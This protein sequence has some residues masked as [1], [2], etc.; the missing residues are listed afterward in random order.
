VK[1]A[2]ILDSGPLGVLCNP[3]NFAQ[4]LAIRAWISALANAGRRV[5]IPKIADYEVR[6][7]LLRNRSFMA[8]ARLNGYGTQ[9]EYSSLTTPSMRLAAELWAQARNAGRQTAHDHALD[10]DVIIAAQAISLGFA[11]IIATGNPAHLSRFTPADL[12][13][14]IVP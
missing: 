7:E 11:T 8:S 14:N 6:R 12:W 10:G 3:N 4:P 9:L 1:D 2:V 5:I 13:Q